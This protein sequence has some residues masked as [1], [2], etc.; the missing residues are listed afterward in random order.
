M[1]RRL[2]PATMADA[3]PDIAGRIEAGTHVLPVRVYYEDTDF[4]GVVYH[5]GYLRFCERG[6]S[7]LL[8]LAGIDHMALANPADG[9]ESLAFVV[10]RIEADFVRAARIDDLLQVRTRFVSQ[11]AARLNIDQRLVRGGADIFRAKVT[12]VLIGAGGRPRRLGAALGSR[13]APLLDAPD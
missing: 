11:S 5:A 9:G 2:A 7:D 6:R 8:R 1:K 4:S 10:S 3:W 12:V 13:L